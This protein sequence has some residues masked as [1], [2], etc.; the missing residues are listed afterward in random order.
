MGN[1]WCGGE[2]SVY[3]VSSNAKS[4]SP[5]QESPSVNSTKHFDK[6]PSNPKEVEDLRRDTAANPL[7]A[8]SYD[9]LKA[10]TGNF[11]QDRVLGGGG[12]GHVYKGFITEELREGLQ[13]IQVAVKVHDGDNSYQGHREWL[14]EVIFLGQLSHPNLVKLIGYCCE[15]E[16][17]VL[18]YEYM[19][20]GSV[21][22]NLFSRVLLPLPWSTRMKIAFGAAKGLAF[23]H[24]AE[25][26][27]I[28][29]DFKT[30]NILLDLDYNAKL[31]DF[32]LAKDGPVGEKSHV[33]TRIM[34]TYGYAA[35]EYIMTG[36]LTSR[37]D[38][39]S[40][41][42]VLLEL[43]TGRKSLDK[44]R[45]AREQNLTDWAVPFLKEKKKIL[46]IADP[47]L[48]GD[49]PVKGLQKAAMLAY[50]CLNRNPKARPLM[51]DIVDSLEPLQVSDEDLIGKGTTL[52]FTVNVANVKTVLP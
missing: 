12:F 31:S 35:P 25:K 44:S 21:E 5:K 34:G 43:L 16:H 8:F 18:I 1:C 20:R 46:N 39:Y 37:S 2:P 32:G 41:G 49:Y 38:V 33:S 4:E 51:R 50:H 7:V 36:H 23:L 47:R 48:N 30:S 52:T 17:R 29:R 45:P 13:P 27:V 14:A 11:R 3:R 40:Y 24:E 22:H 28:Y 6:L 26:P 19:A 15:D 10:I 9:E 42:V